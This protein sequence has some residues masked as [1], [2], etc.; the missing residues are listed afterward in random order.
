MGRATSREFVCLA[1]AAALAVTADASPDSLKIERAEPPKSSRL[2]R[3]ADPVELAITLRYKVEAKDGGEIGLAVHDQLDRPLM[4]Q[5]MPI[6]RVKQG[7]DSI[8][9]RPTIKSLD[10]DVTSVTVEAVLLSVVRSTRQLRPGENWRASL[11][12]KVK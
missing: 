11:T 7:K 3:G 8:T 5:P 12:Y 9:F 1:L 4:T 6:A 2:G 10:A